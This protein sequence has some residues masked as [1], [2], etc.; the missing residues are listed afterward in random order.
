VLAIS[1]LKDEINGMK[2]TTQDYMICC[3]SRS[4]LLKGHSTDSCIRDLLVEKRLVMTHGTEIDIS[5]SFSTMTAWQDQS[6]YSRIEGTNFGMELR[7]CCAIIIEQERAFCLIFTLPKWQD[8]LLMSLAALLPRGEHN[9]KMIV[10]YLEPQVAFVIGTCSKETSLLAMC[11]LRYTLHF[12]LLTAIRM[13]HHSLKRRFFHDM[14]KSKQSKR[15]AR[16]RI[17]NIHAG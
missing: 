11:A 5:S 17:R 16:R 9:S 12:I 6:P 1:L 8:R 10:L 14:G 3:L 13:T 7:C 4:S 15:C 2:S